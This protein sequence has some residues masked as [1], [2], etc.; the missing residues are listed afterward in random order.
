MKTFRGQLR[1]TRRCRRGLN[2]SREGRDLNFAILRAPD[3]CRNGGELFAHVKRNS[4]T[5]TATSRSRP[6]S[7]V[8]RPAVPHQF[9]ALDSTLLASRHKIEASSPLPTSPPRPPS[10]PPLMPNKVPS[11]DPPLADPRGYP[12]SVIS[13]RR[14]P[15]LSPTPQRPTAGPLSPTLHPPANPAPARVIAEW[16][17]TQSRP[18][19]SPDCKY[20]PEIAQRGTWAQLPAELHRARAWG[21]A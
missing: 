15:S 3:G 2:G 16:T 7:L 6:A 18:L 20:R 5:L 19:I 9:F 13:L 10:P 14:H 17:E 4:R 12:A 1:Q 21:S 11:P 8:Q